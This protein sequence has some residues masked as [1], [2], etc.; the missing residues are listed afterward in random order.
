MSSFDDKAFLVYNIHISNNK[1]GDNIKINY[2]KFKNFMI[3]GNTLQEVNLDNQGLTLL[4]GVNEDSSSMDNNG[5]GKSSVIEAVIYALYGKL[6]DGDSGDQLINDQTGK[7]LLVELSFESNNHHYLIKRYRKD[8]KFKNKTLLFQDD[9]EITKS[10]IKLTNQAIENIIGISQDTYLHS[11]FFGLGNNIPF[12]EATDKQKKEILEDAA[13]IAVYKQAQQVAKDKA[14]ELQIS[15]DKVSQAIKI[16]Q[17]NYDYLK[18][19]SDQQSDNSNQL[20][21]K[22]ATLNNDL[23]KYTNVINQYSFDDT[24]YHKL[25]KASKQLLDVIQKISYQDTQKVQAKVDKFK[26]NYYQLKNKVA[27]YQ[28]DYSKYCDQLVKLVRSKDAIC[29]YCGSILNEDHKKKEIG[30]LRDKAIAL[31]PFIKESTNQLNEFKDN[32]EQAKNAL[33]SINQVNQSLSDKVNK[34]KDSFSQ[35]NQK[36]SEMEQSKNDYLNAK[37]KVDQT[38]KLIEATKDSLKINH[39][40]DFSEGL[41]DNLDKLNKLKHDKSTIDK[42]ID[43]YQKVI[44]VYSDQG[45]KAKVLGLLLPYLNERANYYLGYLADGTISVNISSTSTAN[46]GNVSDKMNIEVNNLNGS[47]LYKHNSK[48]ERKRIDLAI[49][50]S[51]QDY[52][53]SQTGATTN[54]IAYDEVFDGLDNAGIDCLISLLKQRIKEVPTILVVSHNDELKSMF[55]NIIMVRKQKGISIIDK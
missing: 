1:V 23:H 46:N 49:S 15:A 54:L 40:N 32:Y 10:S 11:V 18:S 7:N 16:T 29:E 41:K 33:D 35:V 44:S 21:D 9:T 20:K 30:V 37:A 31:K 5:V 25:Q 38:N 17:S 50:L 12:T 27:N 47:H 55:E 14:K 43:D 24:Y 13:N 36:I 19:K 4:T 45:V 51:L 8:T 42:Q 28:T 2:V 22:L 3:F 52:V 39:N 48:G 26:D 34:L 53:L 6:S